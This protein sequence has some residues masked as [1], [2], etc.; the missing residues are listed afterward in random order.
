MKFETITRNDVIELLEQGYK[1]T[2]A[3][4]Y[5]PDHAP[6]GTRFVIYPPRGLLRVHPPKTRN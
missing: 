6:K 2:N 1:L 4:L 5:E 3:G